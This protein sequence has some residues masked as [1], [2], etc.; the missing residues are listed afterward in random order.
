MKKTLLT[1]AALV[2]TLAAMAGPIDRQQALNTAKAFMKDVNA[3]VV[4]Q[5]TTVKHAPGLNG[6]SDVQPYYVFN[7]QNNQGFVIVAGDDRSEEIIG[8]SDEGYFDADNLPHALTDMLEGF[9]E[10]LKEL[11]RQGITEPLATAKLKAPRKAVAQGRH[12]IAPLTTSKWTQGVPFANHTPTYNGNTHAPVGCVACAFGQLLYYWKYGVI[13][14]TGIPGYTQSGGDWDGKVFDALPYREFDFTQMKNSYSSSEANTT[15]GIL[16]GDLFEYINRAFQARFW[17][18]TTYNAF[19]KV[20]T[21]LKKY[22]GY[23]GATGIL[24][25]QCGA[26]E[27]ENFIYNDLSQGVIDILCGRSNPGRHG[28]VVD[29]YSFDDF[30]HI[31]WGWSGQC[32]GYFRLAPLNCYNTST[33]HCYGNHLYGVF[34]ARPN[35]GRLPDYKA[36]V[37]ADVA[38]TD[39]KD[40]YFYVNDSTTSVAKQ[41]A[42]KEFTLPLTTVLENWTNTLGSSYS[43]SFEVEV[44][45]YDA[46][47][48]YVGR[49]RPT[50]T[51]VSVKQ[52][53]TVA[54]NY[55]IGSKLHK[56]KLADGEYKLVPRSRVKGQK[57]YFIDRATGKYAYVKAVK[58]GSTITL[59]LVK[60]YTV[61]SS[62]ILGQLVDGYKAALRVS[63]TNN[64]FTKLTNTLTLFKDKRNDDGVCD[65]Q[66]MRIEPQSTAVIDFGF[67]P[68]DD[69]NSHTLNLVNKD[70]TTDF[71]IASSLY[72]GTTILTKKYT[73][74]TGTAATRKLGYTWYA[75]NSYSETSSSWFNPTTTYYFYGNEFRGYVEI[76]NQGTETYSDVFTLQTYVGSQSYSTTPHYKY[77]STVKVLSIPAGGKAR[78][79]LGEFDYSD[80]NDVYKN[81]ITSAAVS[82]DLYD[83]TRYSQSSDN[84][85]PIASRS[86]TRQTSAYYWWDKNGV[87]TATSTMNSIPEEAVA[88]SFLNKSVGSLQPNGNPNTIYYFTSAPSNSSSFSSKNVVVGSSVTAA[89]TASKAI[90][91]N[92]N[93]DAY[94]PYGFTA[95]AGVSYTRT[96]DYGYEKNGGKGWTTLCLPFTVETIKNGDTEIDWF[97][98][99]QDSGKNF[100]VNQFY[101]EDYT[102]SIYNYTDEI[103]GNTPYIIAVPGAS[104][105][106]QWNLLNKTITFSAGANAQVLGG[107]NIVDGMPVI[108]CDNQNFVGATMAYREIQKGKSVY[109]MDNPGNDFEYVANPNLKSFRAYITKETAN[110][111]VNLQSIA[112]LNIGENDIE[113]EET[114]GIKSI[115]NSRLTIENG[116]VYDLQG[117][118]VS[119]KGL[120]ALPKGIYIMNGKKYTK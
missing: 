40:L 16:I 57:N 11:D 13:P 33:P 52:S 71:A 46:N 115:N 19:E 74:N 53:K 98:T 105:G 43:R 37:P 90:T 70:E 54:V 23:T 91:F 67:F 81:G 49:L 87:M 60:K 44:A 5:T 84:L 14:S 113:G 27:F 25:S 64:S 66:P 8:Y 120:Q 32:N 2:L 112:V 29:G 61:N 92:D 36:Y 119:T 6:A 42:T 69:T 51:D 58:S 22:Y 109:S 118:V 111:L 93:Y 117:R 83:G 39:L 75:D 73:A 65:T 95:K 47:M 110:S 103:A 100:W 24:R 34:G 89:K 97:H 45:V 15:A 30:F 114:D 88:V 72:T 82:F 77:V 116:V 80:L 94:V 48:K 18:G 104:W 78:I 4:L 26:G 38:T 102:M 31:N 62:E 1:L 20:P 86:W 41:T 106:D 7:A 50:V 59:S 55:V 21:N 12:P 85:Q 107:Y 108:D 101:G 3:S 10:D 63:I 96:F 17:Q 35:D 68:G 56:M 28:F 99:N 9:V 76:E 79:D